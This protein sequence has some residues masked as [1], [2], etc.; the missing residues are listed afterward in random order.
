MYDLSTKRNANEKTHAMGMARLRI[1]L[2]VS[3][4]S[5]GEQRQAPNEPSQQS[6]KE[7]GPRHRLGGC[8]DYGRRPKEH[9][10][11]RGDAPQRR[12][13]PLLRWSGCL[14]TG[15]IAVFLLDHRRA[16]NSI[17]RGEKLSFER[18]ARH[19]S[20]L[21]LVDCFFFLMVE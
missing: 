11:E 15:G 14:L 8:A 20:E 19:P 3:G 1:W 16:C 17:M 2:G 9:Q 21:S 18:T 10:L 13:L 6:E 7:A 4:P 5:C 12:G